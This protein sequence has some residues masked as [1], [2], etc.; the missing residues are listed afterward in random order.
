MPKAMDVGARPTPLMV[1]RLE[2]HNPPSA[3]AVRFNTTLL[4]LYVIWNVS[5]PTVIVSPDAGKPAKVPTTLVAWMMVTEL[6]TATFVAPRLTFSVAPF[7]VTVPV[8]S[9]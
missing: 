6:P 8:A 3:H 2:H 1:P 4:L 9:S 7:R 5:L